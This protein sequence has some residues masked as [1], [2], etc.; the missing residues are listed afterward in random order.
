MKSLIILIYFCLLAT[1][2]ASQ[3]D[4]VDN[5][6]G[7]P[8]KE[9][10]T[11]DDAATEELPLSDEDTDTDTVFTKTKDEPEEEGDDVTNF[12]ESEKH[13]KNKK[14][15]KAK[16]DSK[17]AGDDTKARHYFG[18]GS[19]YSGSGDGHHHHKHHKHDKHHH[20]H[21]YEHNHH[22]SS[23][24]YYDDH[25]YYDYHHRRHGHRHHHHHHHDHDHSGSGSGSEA[26]SRFR[27]AANKG[28]DK[29]KKDAKSCSDIDQSTVTGF[30]GVGGVAEITIPKSKETMNV[31]CDVTTDNGG[32]TVF[33]RRMFNSTMSFTKTW[34]EYK[35]GFG[36]F[37]ESFWLGLENMFKLTRKE[38]CEL[39]VDMTDWD[40]VKTYATYKDFK[41]GNEDSKYQLQIGEYKGTAGDALVDQNGMK[42]STHDSD[43]DLSSINCAQV[44]NGGFWFNDCFDSNPN[45]VWVKDGGPLNPG[46]GIVWEVIEGYAE[47]LKTIEMKF[48][49]NK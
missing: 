26:P 23:C 2:V 49:L 13:P 3:D 45:G 6:D 19:G 4:V 22:C 11:T 46:E 28:A 8:E 44:T 36:E 38:K 47:A 35:E 1:F 5:E 25:H 10:G 33:Q 15:P 18:S 17:K 43:N 31:Y 34:N 9:D 29:G 24:S 16:S 12:D 48:R 42:F 39:R 41:I 30:D 27:R 20:G 21:H 14:T 37:D 32:W 7:V 40:G